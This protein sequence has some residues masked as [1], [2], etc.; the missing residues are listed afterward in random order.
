MARPRLEG[1]PPAAGG[2]ARL[3]SL[4]RPGMGFKRWLVV[5]FVGE[6]LLASA[7]ALVLRQLYRE[8]APEGPGSSPILWLL[9]LQFLPLGL[10]PVVLV[11]AGAAVFLFGL[12][13]LM[14]ALME[15]LGGSRGAPLVEMLVRDRTLARGVRIVAIGG[16]TG[17][18]TLLR[19][20]KAHTSNLTA[21]V[22][23]ADDGGSSGKLRTE[24]GMPPMGDIRN[25]IAAL[26]DTE[27][28]M[29]RL[30]QYRF[31]ED[32]EA[33]GGL[34]GHAVGNVLI[35]AL[36]EIEGDFEEGVRKMNGVLAVRGRVVPAA[37][38][39]LTLH[40]ELDDGATRIGQSRIARARGIRRVWV[41]P[42]DARASGDALEAIAA[43]DLVVVGPGSL[44]T[45]LLPCLLVGEIATALRAAAA[46]CVYVANVATQLGETEDFALIDHLDALQRHLG[47]GVFDIVLA[48]GN[49][50]ARAPADW[51]DRPVAPELPESW[52][53]R[54]RFVIADVVDAGNAHHH[55]PEKLALALL[56]LPA[57]GLMRR[58][59]PDA[60]R[61]A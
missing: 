35:A 16:G 40:A 51:P 5:I 58:A 38:V 45:S 39:P 28:T 60:L 46:P 17:L 22:T 10:R 42:L 23:V 20:L 50:G 32:G 12:R 8:A 11:A 7:G 44:F 19:G 18:S 3:R 24:L 26:A 53:R 4:L 41:T 30:L 47:D 56:A 31:P 55:D 25:C 43:A 9:T 34:G 59:R 54:V 14:D 21:I 1:S 52:R 37:P 2:L 49:L 13:R 33:S 61:S 48:N 27:A 36:S 29:T 57:L 6:L 15:P